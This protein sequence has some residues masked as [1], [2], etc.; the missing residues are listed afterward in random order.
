M[1]YPGIDLV[2]P[3]LAELQNLT[4]FIFLTGISANASEPAAAKD[5]IQYSLSPAATRVIKA[6]GMEPL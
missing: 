5:L 2:G 3:I 1:T 4:D 6:K